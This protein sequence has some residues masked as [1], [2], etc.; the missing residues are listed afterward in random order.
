MVCAGYSSKISCIV[1]EPSGRLCATSGS[2]QATLWDFSAGSPAG[3]VPLACVGQKAMVTALA[4]HPHGRLFAS[5]SADGVIKV[6]DTHAYEKGSL[7]E[8]ARPLLKSA[9]RWRGNRRSQPP[10]PLSRQSGPP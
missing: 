9:C 1:W 2:N 7:R 8:G 5:G 6:Y 10:G 4:F 3:T